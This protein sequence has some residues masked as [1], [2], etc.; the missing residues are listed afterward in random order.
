MKT[1]INFDRDGKRTSVTLNQALID[2]WLVAQWAEAPWL[3][4]ADLWADLRK[5]IA[6]TPQQH[7]QTFVESVEVFLL[8]DVRNGIHGLLSKLSRQ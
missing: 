7:G 3:S 1:K 8:Q 5:A 6:E 4:E 2:T